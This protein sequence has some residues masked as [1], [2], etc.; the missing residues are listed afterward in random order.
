MR[1]NLFD[2]G[3]EV[4]Q[5]TYID[6]PEDIVLKSYS[7]SQ[8][9]DSLEAEAVVAETREKYLTVG[10][11]ACTAVLRLVHAF[12][13]YINLYSDFDLSSP[14]AKVSPL[15]A[16]DTEFGF[17][18][19]FRYAL[20]FPV[21][22]P[23]FREALEQTKVSTI[24][25]L[26]YDTMFRSLDCETACDILR[27]ASL[28][29][30]LTDRDDALPKGLAQKVFDHHGGPAAWWI[31]EF[32]SE[33][34][35]DRWDGYYSGENTNQVGSEFLSDLV[36]GQSE[37]R[38]E[39]PWYVMTR[40]RQKFGAERTVD[41]LDVMMRIGDSLQDRKFHFTVPWRFWS[42]FLANEDLHDMPFEWVF[43]LLEG[44]EMC[45]VPWELEHPLYRPLRRLIG[46]RQG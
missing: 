46:V 12:G 43:D 31:L 7:V 16:G 2:R 40:L 19:N 33:L 25:G 15:A 30:D 28:A 20:K 24:G 29:G 45:V 9:T 32:L 34:N 27:L 21:D 38:F 26:G 6:V 42:A 36:L 14:L 35:T 18:S 22:H 13:L 3:K 37:I 5:M 23:D 10:T 8:I 41:I 39:A 11:E 1:K 44:K 17:D 4:T